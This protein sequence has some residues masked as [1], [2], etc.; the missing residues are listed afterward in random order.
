[1]PKRGSS[2]LTGLMKILSVNKKIH[3]ELIHLTLFI[4]Y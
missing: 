2:M 4:S 3:S 1:V